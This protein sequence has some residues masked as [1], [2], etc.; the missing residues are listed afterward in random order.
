MIRNNFLQRKK[1]VL[2]KLDKSSKKSWDKKILKLC[3]EIN[4]KENYYTTSSCSGRVVIIK[5]EKKKGPNLFEFVSHDVVLLGGLKKELEKL[6]SHA[7]DIGGSVPGQV[8]GTSLRKIVKGKIFS[9]DSKSVNTKIP[10]DDGF[11][12]TNRGALVTGNLIF[13]QEPPIL[14]VACKTFEDAQ[15]FLK[16]AQFAG[17][18][19]SGIISCDKNFVVE[20]LS[21][22][23]LEF[24]I[25]SDGKILVSN[26]FLKV[27]LKK[28]NENLK[29][30]WEKV[31]KLEKMIK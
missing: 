5:D 14:H 15:E 27:V 16:K 21:T 9:C 20:M 11:E 13:K 24:P 25:V 10:R 29:K 18:K 28:A 30:G 22:E 4:S 8:Q 23:K 7:R 6:R 19:R 17:W 26:E 1:S 2:L 3:E 12:P 31:R